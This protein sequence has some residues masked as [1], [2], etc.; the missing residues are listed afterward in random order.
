MNQY[1][2][3]R[4]RELLWIIIV[5]LSCMYLFTIARSCA[6]QDLPPSRGCWQDD[7]GVII[8]CPSTRESCEYILGWKHKGKWIR[9]NCPVCPE[10]CEQGMLLAQPSASDPPRFLSAKGTNPEMVLFTLHLDDGRVL[11]TV[12]RR[13]G[14]CPFGCNS[15]MVF[16]MPGREIRETFRATT[17]ERSTGQLT[18]DL[19]EN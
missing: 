8:S 2:G 1:D 13:D 11:R 18:I 6:A 12:A 3:R 17:S 7:A 5:I 19:E 14:I 10:D 16:E 4:I 15:T 9:Y